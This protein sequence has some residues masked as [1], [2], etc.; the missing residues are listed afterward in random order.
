[1]TRKRKALSL[2]VKLVV[3]G[4]LLAWVLSKVHWRDYVVAREAE[5]R[6][7]FAVLE[8]WPDANNPQWLRVSSGMLWWKSESNRPAD[9]FDV[10]RLKDGSAVGGLVQPGF[11]K[12]LERAALPL[13][14]VA[15]CGYVL[16]LSIIG[17]RWW[18]LLRIQDIRI[19]LW[20]AQ[21]LTFLGQFYNIVIPGT[22]GG[23]LVKAY[24]IARHTPK[25][26]GALVSIFV[27]R[28]LGFAELGFLA[29]VTV[30]IFWATG[31][32]PFSELRLAAGL[33]LAF[34]AAI[35]G[36][37]IFLL[38]PG[39]RRALRLQKI[40]QRLPIAHHIAAAGDAADLYRRR[41]G[42]LT[43]AIVMT[44]GAQVMWICSIGLIGLALHNRTPF[45]SYLVFVPLIYMCA[46]FV[47]VPGGVGPV[48]GAYV[49]FFATGSSAST[50][51]SEILALAILARLMDIAR[52]LPGLWVAI[53]GPRLPKAD[54][55][56]AV[57]EDREAGM[58]EIIG[59]NRDAPYLSRR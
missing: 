24:Y 11:Q 6:Q 14:A 38:V 13:L 25:K 22:I 50:T 41:L 44:L 16:S 28:V 47:P 30:L 43:K 8:A 53:T 34:L 18:L 32:M 49:F 56:E 9:D 36:G 31:L 17:V 5:N 20:E 45:H 15:L 7:E 57:L 21:K 55:M 42:R 48:E 19:P 58:P 2:I 23:D 52:G 29:G 1:V 46:S 3:A 10:L 4:S 39:F 59:D 35:C 12:T 37:L 26:A 51:P 54:T 33:S 40:Y 27:D